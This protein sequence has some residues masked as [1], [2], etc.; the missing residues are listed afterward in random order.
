MQRVLT[1]VVLIPI[2]LLV[3][4]KAPLWLYALVLVLFALQCTREY[5]NIV[6]AHD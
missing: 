4:F 5:L 3:L 1:A 2:V 6:A